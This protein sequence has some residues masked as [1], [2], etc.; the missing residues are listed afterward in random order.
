MTE[1]ASARPL[2]VLNLMQQGPIIAVI[3]IEQLGQAVPLAQALV[4]GGVRVLEVT[5]RTPVALEGIYRIGQEVPEAIVGAGT[6]VQAQQMQAAAQAGAKFVV[7]PGFTSALSRA[8][9]DQQLAWLPGVA[10]PSEMM[11]AME[12]GHEALKFFPAEENGGLAA[13]KALHGPF[14]NLRFCPTGGIR[15][16]NAREYLALPNVVCV[17]SSCLSSSASIQASDWAGITRNAQKIL[18]QLRL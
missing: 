17:G 11:L 4:A 15:E 2:K 5:L 16:H 12:H 3:I 6:V 9:Q 13:L 18:A 14:P 7:S 10:T 8:A 1:A